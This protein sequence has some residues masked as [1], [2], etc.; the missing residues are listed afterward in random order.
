M[1]F[2][3]LCPLRYLPV[4]TGSGALSRVD[5]GLYF[6]GE[7]VAS[8]RFNILWKTEVVTIDRLLRH[9]L[10]LFYR[11]TIYFKENGDLLSIKQ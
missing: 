5:D 2:T 9:S 10:K 3:M 6:I 7:V 4:V 11:L 1:I 8:Q